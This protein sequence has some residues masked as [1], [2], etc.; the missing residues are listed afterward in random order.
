MEIKELLTSFAQ[1][2]IFAMMLSMGLVLRFEGI[3]RLWRRPSLLLRSIIA[4]FVVVPLAAM[5]VVH[6]IPLSFEVRAGI[7]AMA[8]IPGA[9]TIYRKMLKGDG[10]PE[11]VG[12]FQATMAI[13]SIML[14]PV[15]FGVL[16]ALY[17]AVASAPLST[18]FKQVMLM[19][20]LPLLCGAA[21]SQWLPDLAEEFNEPLNRISTAML[22]GV[23]LLVLAIGLPL[24][25][26][27]GP[28]P[29]L[30]VVLMAAVALLSGH[31]LGG[32]DPMTRQTI[33][34]A[35]A[36][37]NAG[38][39]I[40]LITLNFPNAA[41]EILITIAAY[42]VIGAISGKIYARLHQKRLATS[43]ETPSPVS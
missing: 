15:W 38:L 17:P 21:I 31:Y 41:H 28:L 22:V 29:V 4:A 12:S 30:A 43:T 9:P 18:V 36:T 23:V 40:A 20:G 26:K 11:L 33:A 37:R 25:L 10:N 16:S 7:A 42:A 5:A 34:I 3:A 27:A 2:A 14:V 13:L 32:L 39:A 35:N 24:V 1:I 8:V 6:V 19:Q